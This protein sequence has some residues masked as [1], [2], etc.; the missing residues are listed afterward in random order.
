M[1]G[2]KRQLEYGTISVRYGGSLVPYTMTSST[3]ESTVHT[4]CFAA[5][6][7]SSSDTQ[8]HLHDI[9]HNVT[10]QLQYRAVLRS[11]SSTSLPEPIAALITILLL[12]T[13]M[14]PAR[15]IN[16]ISVGA[17]AMAVHRRDGFD[18]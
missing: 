14:G 10:K 2:G 17:A 16:G 11:C 12:H 6:K 4:C 9:I 5:L 7:K 3:E 13:A 18:R 8:S 15:I 1:E